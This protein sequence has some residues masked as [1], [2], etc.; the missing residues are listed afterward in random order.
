MPPKPRTPGRAGQEPVP[1]LAEAPP[2][3][4][5]RGDAPAPLSEADPRQSVTARKR[6][7]VS[8]ADATRE[9]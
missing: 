3:G 7:G 8:E 5:S 4:A 2:V 6:E 9:P 1:E